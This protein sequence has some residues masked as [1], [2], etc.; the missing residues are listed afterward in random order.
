MTLRIFAWSAALAIHLCWTSAQS[1]IHVYEQDLAGFT[2]ATGGVPITIDFDSIA[3]GTDITGQTIAGVRFLAGGA[4]LIVVPGASTFTPDGFGGI[5]D[6]S[7]NR[8]F[9]TS[10]ANVLSPGG[11]ELAPGPDSGQED[12]VTMEFTPPVF[13]VGFDHL[14]QSADGFGF[15]FVGV[16]DGSGSLLYSGS[17]PISNVGGMGGGAPGAADFW[18]V[19]SATSNIARIEIYELDADSQ[20]PDCNIGMDSV[21]FA[22]GC[23][24]FGDTDGNCCVDDADLTA[25]ILDFGDPPSGDNG[26]TDINGDSIVDDGDITEVILHYGD[27]C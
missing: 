27:G 20:Y 24:V 5:I 1:Q 25:V 16:Y 12:S 22:V 23:S 13:A 21:R 6:A 15:S 14:S 18:G 2:A 7:T 3:P 17:V 8:L 9:P 11:L 19:V 10:G 4:A 26:D